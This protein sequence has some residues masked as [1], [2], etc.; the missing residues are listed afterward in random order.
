MNI[1][2][3]KRWHVRTKA[4]IARVRRDEREAAILEQNLEK[5]K[6]LA[7]QEARNLCLSE[8]AEDAS[9]STT[10]GRVELFD[11]GLLP[12]KEL[13]KELKDATDNFE[14]KL[15]V[16]TYL[17]QS[18]R[19]N[20]NV[21]RPWYTRKRIKE[22]PLIDEERDLK[23]KRRD[24]PLYTM[25]C[26]NLNEQERGFD[27]HVLKSP[28]TIDELRKERHL[29]ESEEKKKAQHL[30]ARALGYQIPSRESSEL[31]EMGRNSWQYNPDL[32]K[33]NKRRRK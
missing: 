28:C 27:Q 31:H 24:D 20:N 26:Y 12:N 30:V 15:G 8:K 17:G 21:A 7:D 25:K 1:L 22:D 29:R 13:Q 33:Q 19:D 23:W 9:Q 16:L 5:R 18:V 6:I 32:A 14:K 2:P 4:N 11:P 10:K 3:K